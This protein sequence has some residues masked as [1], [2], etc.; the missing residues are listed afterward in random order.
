MKSITRGHIK[1]AF[2][3][4]R[5]SKW[6]S[7]LTML[8]I[9][10]GIVSVVTIVSIGEGIKNQVVSQI[11][12][13]ADG[14]I[15]VRPGQLVNRDDQGKITGVNLFSGF[16]TTGA[17]NN[18]DVEIIARTSGVEKA[19]PLS[20]VAG[21]ISLG[22]KSY[23]NVA[24]IGTTPDLP[25]ALKQPI[26]FGG[27]FTETDENQNGA[28][29]GKSVA[30]NIFQDEVPLGNGFTFMGQDFIVRGLFEEFNNATLSLDTDFNNAIFIPY[31]VA[32]SLTDNNTALYQILAI[33][34]NP[35][36]ADQVAESIKNNLKAAHGNQE[37]FTILKQNE[38][39]NVTSNILNLLTRLIGGIAAISL[40]VGGIG[41]MN[42][43]LVS[44][45][46]R[47]HEI[48]I[49]K[50]IGATSRQIMTQFLME[51]TVLS[52]LGGI[53]G[54]ALAIVLNFLLR[55]FTNIEPIVSWQVVLLAAGVSLLVGIVF[56]TAPALKAAR[57]DPI[58]AL[59]HE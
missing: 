15:T 25:R 52:V 28:I 17:L 54:V 35:A 20:I 13:R 42:V 4:V 16:A 40:I 22:G 53:I 6:R 55:I 31:E 37:D 18:R 57:K 26:E 34:K 21:D 49:R 29:I 58:E 9:I 14:L 43:M 46:E 8:G 50:A 19:V 10:I 36:K 23:S 1:T 27:F 45:T 3:S 32:G 41:I 11:N 7:L 24:V 12:N 59:R 47:M 30:E 39:L 2:N 51:A 48:G 38:S 33:P 5:S 56:G 44:I